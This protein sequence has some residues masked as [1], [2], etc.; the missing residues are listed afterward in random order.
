MA[1]YSINLPFARRLYRKMRFDASRPCMTTDNPPRLNCFSTQNR[2]KKLNIVKRDGTRCI[3]ERSLAFDSK[4]R[5]FPESIK[6][7]TIS[8]ELAS[9]IASL[10]RQNNVNALLWSGCLM[11]IYCVSSFVNTVR[12]LKSLIIT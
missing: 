1:S 2:T 6:D 9:A 4:H 7:L 12:V 5:S 8:R 10:L 3:S 11:K